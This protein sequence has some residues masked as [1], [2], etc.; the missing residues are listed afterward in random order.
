MIEEYKEA[1]AREAGKPFPQETT[2]QLWGAIAAVF[3]SWHNARAKTYRRLHRIPDGWG[4]AVNVQAMVFG[5][6]GEGSATG[7]AFTRNPSTGTREVYGEFLLN[8][9]GEDVV[10]GIR[11]PQPLTE[12]ARAEAGEKLPSLEGLMPQTY[13]ELAQVFATLEKHYREMQD[14]EFTIQEGKLWMLQTRAGKRTT[15]AALKI[16]VDLCE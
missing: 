12:K 7:V 5:N 4:T 11:T 8:A 15:K 16:A 6:L 1:V 2:D 9:Q 10:A 3:G 13:G 14:V